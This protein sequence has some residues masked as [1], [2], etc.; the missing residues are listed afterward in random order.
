MKKVAA[1]CLDAIVTIVSLE[2]VFSEAYTAIKTMKAP[3]IIAEALV[4]MMQCVTDFGSIG[5][6]IKEFAAFVKEQLAS[7]AAPVR[8]NAIALLVSVRQYGH[9]G[10]DLS[11]LILELRN[12]FND[13]S[14]ALQVSIDSEF[15]KLTPSSTAP[16]KVQKAV[17]VAVK[18]ETSNRIDLSTVISAELVIVG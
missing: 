16:T 12:Y 2:Y 8:T 14:P 7:A 18:E 1:S 10:F 9:P 17:L 4:W 6:K 11:V 15:S 5:L 3:K 13:I